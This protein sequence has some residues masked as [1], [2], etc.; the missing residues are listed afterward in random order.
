M[1]M[2]HDKLL[3]AQRVLW[4][5]GGNAESGAMQVGAKLERKV[6][7]AGVVVARSYL[8]LF[9]GGCFF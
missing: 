4:L 8:E 3:R 2:V 1:N 9:R 5:C 6:A 7:S